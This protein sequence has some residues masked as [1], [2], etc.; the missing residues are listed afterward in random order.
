MKL[1]STLSAAALA[2]S[3]SGIAFAQDQTQQQPTGDQAQRERDYQ[4]ELKK[5]DS[6]AAA[7]KQKCIDAAKKKFGQM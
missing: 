3:L 2:L 1:I 6:L 4:A 7:E 5:C